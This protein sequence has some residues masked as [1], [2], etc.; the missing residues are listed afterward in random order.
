MWFPTQNAPSTVVR[1]KRTAQAARLLLQ[2]NEKDEPAKA[3]PSLS[4]SL[5]ACN[6][7]L[8]LQANPT[9]LPSAASSR[10]FPLVVLNRRSLKL[11]K[12]R[13]HPVQPVLR[14]NAVY[15]SF[16]YPPREASRAD[17]QLTFK[18]AQS[19]FPISG[20]IYLHI[21]FITHSLS[22]PFLSSLGHSMSK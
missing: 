9:I 7:S 5:F 16:S 2:N 13:R 12:R 14:V 8:A 19:F 3:N 15:T 11:S 1:R 4:L 10:I 22:P 6:A 17:V 18:F 21:R 20:S